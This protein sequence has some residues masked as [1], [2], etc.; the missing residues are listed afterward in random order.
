MAHP[1]QLG[2]QDAASPII[3]ELTRFRDHALM[4]VIL[5]SA[6]VLYFILITAFAKLT[7][8]SSWDGPSFI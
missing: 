3:E 8:V 6:F 2:L 5:V 7:S 4:T 1:L